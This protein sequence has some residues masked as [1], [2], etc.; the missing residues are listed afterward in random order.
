[1]AFTLTNHGFASLYNPRSVSLVLRGAKGDVRMRFPLPDID[2]RLWK[3]SICMRFATSVTLPED[4]AA[5]TYSWHLH[6]P[7]ASPRLAKDPRFSVRFA[8]KDIWNGKTGEHRL[9]A[10]WKVT[11]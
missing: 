11:E 5:G 9:A 2:P 4:L 8:N 6:L 10:N 7:D 3:P 1:M